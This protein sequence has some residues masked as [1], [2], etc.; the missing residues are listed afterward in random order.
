MRQLKWEILRDLSTA[1]EVVLELSLGG[2]DLESA[3][4]QLLLHNMCACSVMSDS[5]I[6]WSVT[7][8]ASL[9]M[10]FSWQEYWRGLP[11]PPPGDLP[12]PGTEPKS[13]FTGSFF[14]T[15]PHGQPLS[16]ISII[17]LWSKHKQGKSGF[18]PFESPWGSSSWGTKSV[19][20][21]RREL[22]EAVRLRVLVKVQ[23]LC[24]S[25]GEGCGWA[26]GLGTS[27]ELSSQLNVSLL[28][29]AASEPELF[30]NTV[31]PRTC[32]PS[33]LRPT[34][35]RPSPVCSFSQD[36][37]VIYSQVKG[38]STAASKPQFL[39]PSTPHRWVHTAPDLVG[40][41]KPPQATPSIQGPKYPHLHLNKTR[42]P[43][44]LLSTSKLTALPH[45]PSSVLFPTQG[46]W[47]CLA[48]L[49]CL[50]FTHI[51]TTPPWGWHPSSAMNTTCSQS[52]LFSVAI[53][54]VWLWWALPNGI[55]HTHGDVYIGFVIDLSTVGLH[56]ILTC[57]SETLSS[58]SDTRITSLLHM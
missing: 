1:A 46:P 57:L 11:F 20:M 53:S 2:L 42:G 23:W 22:V 43:K 37:C 55:A 18:L 32:A 15:E 6:P 17:N 9:S 58:A 47:C 36:S 5:V 12:D 51:P 8:L 41:F 3:P 48:S 13:M 31:S 10:G 34:G 24:R 4:S 30:K 49:L 33:H 19:A 25:H 27:G 26:D 45:I 21:L 52:M 54:L 7:H 44:G 28:S 50:S 16:I 29:T 14:T 40:R 39:D 56:S 35:L 38:A